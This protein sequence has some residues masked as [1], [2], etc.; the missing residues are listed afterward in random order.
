MPPARSK[1]LRPYRPTVSEDDREHWDQR[2]AQGGSTPSRDHG[3]PPAFTSVGHLFPTEGLALEIACGRGRAAVWLALRGMEVQAVDVSPV[4]TDLAREL[5]QRVGV[6]ER[7]HFQ[8]HDLDAGLPDGPR[9]ALLLCHLFRDPRLDQAMVARVTPGG[10]LAV[11][12]LSEVGAGPGRFRA[13]PGELREA[14]ARLETLAEGEADGVAW[15]LGRRGN[16]FL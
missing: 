16:D 8:V 3:P 15:F 9:V 11:S 12:V 10:L 5:A 13:R 14:F 6:A 1:E 2:F 7:C 4:A